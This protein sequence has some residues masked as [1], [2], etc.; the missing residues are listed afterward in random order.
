M[1]GAGVGAG[2]AAQ[3]LRALLGLPLSLVSFH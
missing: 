2:R 3:L 1:L